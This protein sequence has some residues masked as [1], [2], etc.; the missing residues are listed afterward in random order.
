MQCPA[1]GS[2]TA[3]ALSRCPRC[4]APLPAPPPPGDETVTSLSPEP[5]SIPEPEIWRPP[6]PPKRSPLPYVALGAGVVLLAA[7]ALAIVFWPASDKDPGPLLGSPAQ[8]TQVPDTQSGSSGD[9]A[10]RLNQQAGQVDTLL[11]EMA[12]TRN[13]L[14][15][16][17][18]GG[19]QTAALERV[20]SQREEQLA[21]ARNLQ[22][23]ALENGPELR[24]ALIRALEA[25][26]E[27]NRRYLAVAPG[28]PTES[29]VASVN[30]RASEAKRAFIDYWRPNAERA[31]L[32][33]RDADEI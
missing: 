32:D 9:A 13:E 22:V 14:G 8:Q 24:D 18:T 21:K 5:W 4:D 20:R 30:E 7:V 23:D 26:I 12:G 1:C 33:V 17:V 3:P 6:P 10:P 16:A 15:G 25:A 28:C 2:D 29:E 27:S 11:T 31:G 19:C